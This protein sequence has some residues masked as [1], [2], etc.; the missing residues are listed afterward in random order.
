MRY[1]LRVRDLLRPDSVLPP[2]VLTGWCVRIGEHIRRGQPLFEF[3]TDKVDA[4]IPFLFSGRVDELHV[5]PGTTLELEMPLLTFEDVAR[6]RLPRTRPDAARFGA[7]RLLSAD[8][9]APITDH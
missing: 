4:E 5:A 7:Q 8:H 6:L 1:V 3:S 9:R 2:A